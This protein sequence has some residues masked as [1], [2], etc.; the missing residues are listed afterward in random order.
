MFSALR[1]IIFVLHFVHI[2][3]G[4]I[5]IKFILFQKILSA[6]KHGTWKREASNEIK[7]GTFNHEKNYLIL[8]NIEKNELFKTN[9]V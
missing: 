2:S 1:S 9:L 5:V 4:Q 8:V 3:M 6:I 7:I